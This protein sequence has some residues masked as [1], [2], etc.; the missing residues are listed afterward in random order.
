MNQPHRHERPLSESL[1]TALAWGG[2]LIIVGVVFGLTP[3]I[4]SA[5][6]D[7]FSDLTGVTYPG[8]YGTI[9]LP[10][11]AN[12]AAHQTVYQ[13]V[14]NFMLAIG[15]LQIVILAARLLVHSTVK[16]TAETVGNLIWWVGGAV[17]AYVYLMAGTVSGWF[18]FWPMLIILA[19]VS[20]IVQGVIRIAYRRL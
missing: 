1:I 12:P 20:L 2:F 5:I 10:A 19:G 3:G 7:F 18:T 15:V 11:P 14:F 4:G 17:A 6:G 13:A 9:M 8:I 16:R